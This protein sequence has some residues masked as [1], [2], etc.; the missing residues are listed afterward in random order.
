MLSPPEA[1]ALKNKNK[2]ASG[3]GDDTPLLLT[4]AAIDDGAA[5]TGQQRRTRRRLVLLAALSLA[6]VALLGPLV[7][8]LLGDSH[9]R[10]TLEAPCPRKG[11]VALVLGGEGEG[12]GK[13]KRDLVVKVAS[14]RRSFV[15]LPD[16]ADEGSVEGELGDGA[17]TVRCG[18]K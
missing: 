5:T 3:R 11:G 1:L 2:M 13:Q 6:F 8:V 15:S 9:R 14:G 16:D 17:F 4:E 18:K 10:E 7:A 12:G